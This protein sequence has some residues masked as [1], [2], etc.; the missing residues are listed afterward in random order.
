[1]GGAG[2]GGGVTALRF[3]GGSPRFLVDS[4]LFSDMFDT[5]NNESGCSA[6]KYYLRRLV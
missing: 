6:S 4:L 2:G 1:M 5:Q 3:S